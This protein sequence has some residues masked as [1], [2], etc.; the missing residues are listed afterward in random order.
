M[1]WGV[2]SIAMSSSSSE[3]ASAPTAD[4]LMDH[5]RMLGVLFMVLLILSQAGNAAAAHLSANAG[6]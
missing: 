1:V 5:P 6:P 4:F 3:T 2:V